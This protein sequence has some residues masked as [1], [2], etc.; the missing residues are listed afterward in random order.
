MTMLRISRTSLVR[1][2][3]PALVG[4]TLSSPSC[5]HADDSPAGAGPVPEALANEWQARSGGYLVAPARA[6]ELI[7]GGALLVDARARDRFTARHLAGAANAPWEAFTDGPGRGAVSSDD[8]A[9]RDALESAGIGSDRPLVVY[10]DWSGAGPSSTW[11]EEGRIAWMFEYLGHERVHVLHGGIGAAIAAGWATSQGASAIASR[12]SFSVRRQER[13]RVTG[14]DI[15]AS[16]EAASSLRLVDAREPV[17][18]S[19][20]VRYG[21]S[22]GGHIPG[23][24]HFWWYDVFDA[25]GNLRRP[26]ELEEVF[27]SLRRTSADV[28]VPYCTGGIRSGFVYVVARSLG[29]PAANYDASMWEWTANDAWPVQ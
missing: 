9:L 25:A 5:G 8:V 17:E 6:A 20:T 13:L 26:S 24:A 18:F 1:R 21:E 7:A 19:G 28:L 10:G 16:L 27:A 3:L 4:L 29:I 23:A 14:E 11:G 15:A 22:R 12:G 2:L